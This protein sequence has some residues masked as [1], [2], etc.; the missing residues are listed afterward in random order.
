MAVESQNLPGEPILLL[1]FVPPSDPMFEAQQ[2]QL[3]F[4]RMGQFTEP[5]QYLIVDL[6]QAEISFDNVMVSM[7][8]MSQTIPS[9][10]LYIVHVGTSEML[11]LI[12]R[13]GNQEHS[14]QTIIFSTVDDALAHI[15]AL[16]EHAL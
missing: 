8:E 5:P 9:I 2:M 11:H 13:M 1:R 6:S 16:I 12:C 4:E 7:D 3:I 10:P 15:H 14:L